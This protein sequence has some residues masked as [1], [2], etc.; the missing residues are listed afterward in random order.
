M[1]EPLRTPDHAI[2]T[3]VLEGLGCRAVRLLIAGSA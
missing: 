2:K 3:A 1:T